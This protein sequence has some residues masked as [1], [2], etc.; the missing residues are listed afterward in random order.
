MK[1]LRSSEECTELY[2]SENR[3][4]RRK[5]NHHSTNVRIDDYREKLRNLSNKMDM[6][7]FQNDHFVTNR[8]A[9]MDKEY[10][11]HGRGEE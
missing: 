3:D 11:T 6:T 8:E 4:I 1:F 10:S 9:A 5:H 2:K 7:Y